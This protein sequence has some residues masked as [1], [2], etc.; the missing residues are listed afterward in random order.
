[1][2]GKQ[3]ARAGQCLGLAILAILV[4]SAGTG[5]PLHGNTRSRIFHQSSCRYYSCPNCTARFDTEREARENGYRP[6][7]VC[8]PGS[9]VRE[10][11]KID[12]AYVGNTRSHKFHSSHCRY[13]GCAN[14]S[15]KFK[16]R[17]EAIEAGYAPGGCCN[18]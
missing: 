7:G 18:P 2:D 1:M 12:A 14:C 16:T 5:K 9:A 8:N 3:I 6:C 10:E 15:A 4:V 13:A 17:E 11:M